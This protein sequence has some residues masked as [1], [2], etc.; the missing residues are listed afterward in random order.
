LLYRLHQAAM[1]VDTAAAADRNNNH[2]LYNVYCP[3]NDLKKN[4]IKY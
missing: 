4:K 1:I 3:H 2:E